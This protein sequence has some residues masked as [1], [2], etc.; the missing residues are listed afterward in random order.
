MGKFI[1]WV[2]GIVF[3]GLGLLFAVALP[4]LSGGLGTTYGR[5]GLVDALAVYVGLHVAVGVFCIVCALRRSYEYALLLGFLV[6]L[7]LSGSRVVAMVTTHTFTGSQ[8]LLLAP[9]LLGVVLIGAGFY[10]ENSRR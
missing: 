8:L 2:L 9:E 1:A 6:T 10:L 5:G 7:G 4:E 3:A